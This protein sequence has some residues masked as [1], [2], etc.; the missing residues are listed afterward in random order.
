MFANQAAFAHNVGAMAGISPGGMA[1]LSMP[2]FGG[3]GYGGQELGFSTVTS[4]GGVGSAMVG[5]LGS[6]IPGVAAGMSLAGGMGF[7]GSMG[8]Y[9][10]PV[11]GVGRS[12]MGGMAGGSGL[13]AIG[14][15][16]RAAAM[17]A[18]GYY[19]AYK[20]LS[21]IGENIYG[22]AQNISQV[23]GMAQ[24]YFGPQ[25]GGAGSRPGGFMAR[26]QVQEITSILHEIAGQDTMTSMRD[27]KRL[28]DQAGQFGML[29]GISSASEF[30]DKFKRIVGQAK[31]VAEILGTTIEEGMGT[32]SSFKQMGM[33]TTQDV[34]GGAMA[35]KMVGPQ[36][37]GALLQTMQAGAQ[38]SHAMGGS[39]AAGAA[40]GRNQFLNVQAAQTAGVLS[41]E[42]I[43]E[44]TGGIGGVE[45][46][47]ILAER[48]TGM[49]Q[50]MT[51]TPI[52]RLSMAG[53]GEM[54]DGK[55]TGR[56]N[57]DLMQRFQ[58]GEITVGELQRLGSKNASTREGA[59]SFTYRQ[60][61]LGQ[62][63]MGQGGIEMVGSMFQAGLERAGFGGASDEI[64]GLMLQKM[65]G[66]N[67]RDAQMMQRLVRDIPRM[68]EQRSRRELAALQD[69][70]RQLDERRNKSWQGLKDV[71]THAFEETME[72]PLQE[73]G[74]SLSTKLNESLDSATDY[75]LG[76]TRQMNLTDQERLRM[77][78]Q[79]GGR[80]GS[81][82]GVGSFLASSMQSN[83]GSTSP[84]E[85]MRNSGVFSGASNALAS[86][87]G[88][89]TGAGT[90]AR[91]LR[92]SGAQLSQG[93][94]AAG[95]ILVSNAGGL[96]A[97]IS[98]DEARRVTE[99]IRRR[100]SGAT[101][102]SDLF[103]SG[104]TGPAVN[105]ALGKIKNAY[106]TML[107][108]VTVRDKL[109]KMQKEMSP[110]KY[111]QEVLSLLRRYGGDVDGAL[112]VLQNFSL[113]GRKSLEEVGLDALT[114]VQ[115][116]QSW[117][118]NNLA[119]D[120]GEISS[121]T[122]ASMQ[123]LLTDGEAF[124][125]EVDA[126]VKEIMSSLRGGMSF[127]QASD[128]AGPMASDSRIQSLMQ[129]QDIGVSETELRTA[130]TEKGQVSE[131]LRQFL[132]DGGTV[133]D[134]SKYPDLHAAMQK[135]ST[136]DK[137][138]SSVR[139]GGASKGA[140]GNLSTLMGGKVAAQ[141]ISGIGQSAKAELGRLGAGGPASLREVLGMFSKAG[142]TAD[143]DLFEKAR[144]RAQDA[145]K[146]LDDSAVK[147]LRALGGPVADHMADLAEVSR[148]KLAGLTGEEARRKIRAAGLEDERMG[149][150]V[151]NP[152]LAKK[153]EELL[154]SKNV[155]GKDQEATIK[156]ALEHFEKTAG[157]SGSK[158]AAENAQE[159]LMANLKGF[160]GANEAFVL[161]VKEAVPALKDVTVEK[162]TT[163]A[164]N[165][166]ENKATGGGSSGKGFFS[167]IF[168]G[169]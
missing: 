134:P 106:S 104:R 124:S 74:E 166:S 18:L 148:L 12:F 159:Q 89:E 101:G 114:V 144:G 118:S 115:N 2:S 19:A 36:G 167:T 40:L 69:S 98:M 108:D 38:M 49:M 143:F 48:L 95:E 76:R 109:K 117:R 32:M 88:F 97:V 131:Q 102:A 141:A 81:Q 5:G 82:A 39:L 99:D 149:L 85:R 78:Y 133:V 53:L 70:L 112:K 34:M 17:P 13:G 160:V 75:L 122:G 150:E 135:D 61:Q 129:G 155:I 105:E 50:S 156:S 73:L 55:F 57:K 96:D 79:S 29:T 140:V 51:Q 110:T 54:R 24:Q 67:R 65:Y 161:A 28:M 52:G 43:Q 142:D 14:A 151:V 47:Q 164:R 145:A 64:Q 103:K 154:G 163:A 152:E 91:M 45:G 168:G 25:Y 84:V 10:D 132:K 125:K 72:R 146:E 9:L 27:L 26:G 16:V 121:R 56:I 6:A 138:V 83:F 21:H 93:T 35:M 15:G 62:E 11:T 33:W 116:D 30:K 87:F 162:I 127:E 46:Q 31:Q 42:M 8:G 22:G 68:Q 130:L 58:R 92:E 113:D 77:M 66:L 128:L 94:G 126:N 147:K 158:A 107:S 3:I 165:I 123:Q 119:V 100:G 44:Y 111:A 120:F 169:N 20:G 80:V 41:P 71:V 63:M 136:I 60:E 1:P 4:P 59:A 86:A 137:I 139:G 90:R 37:R 23:G 153:L 7:L 157:L